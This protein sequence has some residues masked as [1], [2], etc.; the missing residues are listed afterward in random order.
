MTAARHCSL[1]HS[2]RRGRVATNK[3]TAP[4]RNRQPLVATG[5]RREK[6]GCTNAADHWIEVAPRMMKPAPA[7]ETRDPEALMN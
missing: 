5:P 6:A 4:N 3:I 2:R 7:T 1:F